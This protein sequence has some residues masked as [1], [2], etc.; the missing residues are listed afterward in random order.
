MRNRDLRRAASV[1]ALVAGLATQPAIAGEATTSRGGQAEATPDA[2]QPG[3]KDQTSPSTAAQQV[4]TTPAPAAGVTTPATANEIV[5]TGTHLAS[6]GFT[7]PTPVTVVGAEQIQQEAA[8]NIADVLGQLP[9]FRAQSSPA[10]TA[11][12]INNAGANLAD[13]RGLGANRTLVL[14]DGRRFVA[15][16]TSGGGFSPSA[17]VDLNMIPTSL[18]KRTEVVTGG[19]SANYGSDAVAGVVNLILDT[20]LTGIRG[21]IQK[22]ISSRGDNSDLYLSLAGGTDF[23]GGRGHIVIGGEYDNNKGVGD[24]YSR[25]WCAEAYNTIPVVGPARAAND[26]PAQ[27]ILPHTI[28]VA[29]WGGVITSGPLRGVAFAPNGSIYQHDFGT[30]YGAGIFQS[31]GGE[32]PE[33]AFYNGFLL[34]APVKRYSLMAHGTYQLTD[35]IEAFVE[36]NIAHVKATTIGAQPRFVGPQIVIHRDNAYIS[37]ELATL[38][39]ANGVT[40]FVLNRIGE[41]FGHQV[42]LVTRDL[43]RGAVGLKGDINASWRWDA[44]YQYGETDYHQEGN[45]VAITGNPAIPL[46]GNFYNAVDAVRDATGNIVC[47]ATLTNPSNP[48]V[49]GCI[50]INIFGQ[51]NWD[52]AAKGYSFGNAIQ[53]TKLTQN[54]AALN[55]QGDLFDLPGG[56]LA[57]AVGGEYRVEDVSGTADPIS[58]ELRFYTSPGSGIS[59]PAIKVKE[60]YVELGAPI[61]ADVPFAHTLSLNGAYRYTDYSTSGGVS[62]WKVGA[63]WEPIRQLRFRVTRSRDIRAPNFFELYNPTVSSFQNVFDPENGGQQFLVSTRS[64]GNPNLKP[65]K[66]DTF[67]AGVVISPIGSLRLSLDYYDI[68]LN[69]AISTVGAQTIVTGCS[70]GNVQYCGFV[71]RDPAGMLAIVTNP[72]LNVSKLKS[73]GL[74]IEGSYSTQVGPG[75]LSI[76]ALATRLFKYDPI[77]DGQ[78][79]AGMNG[80]PV[81]VPSGLPKWNVNGYLT[82]SL[83][84]VTAGLEV[85]YISSGIYN[86][87]LIGPGQAGYD[88]SLPN[89]VSN[90]HVPAKT[91]VNLNASVD[92]LGSGARKVQVFGVVDNLFDVDPPNQMPSSFAVTNPALYD[93]VGR[94]FR[95]GVRFAY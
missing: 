58:S 2:A 78:N 57:L 73:R 83:S 87:A 51:N 31:G 79:R 84:P 82:Y 92:V 59:G 56:P 70:G 34:V 67:T 27:V 55:V 22:G 1:I 12:F 19:A 18:I 6:S 93:V 36:G 60:G 71:Q 5:V 49:Q 20:D 14:V 4:P 16:T 8:T 45:N 15:G 65:E 46:S 13:L 50:P 61:L 66:A 95:F 85:R 24:C 91:Y 81:S 44:Y 74:D 21:T 90:N 7:A 26:L 76:R 47:R 41:D 38:M 37:P 88:P 86:V 62:T 35:N 89:S 80:S 28:P 43:Y 64:G 33:N 30:F 77:G 3:Q 29:T 39:D 53:D 11:I 75:D 32:D 25:S 42:G 48:Y 52:P 69:G 68:T 40:S 10:T 63:V 94:T 54:V 17:T 72:Y 9:S 23:A